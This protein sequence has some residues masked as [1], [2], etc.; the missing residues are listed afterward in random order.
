MPHFKL[1]LIG[2]GNVAKSFV[3]LLERKRSVLESQHG[4]TFSFVGV[5][6]GQH[7][8]AVDM[9][10]LDPFLMR[11]SCCL[12]HPESSH[13]VIRMCKGQADVMFETSP[14]NNVTGQPAIEHVALA[15][16]SGM[17]VITANK[18]TVVHGYNPLMQTAAEKE[19]MFLHEATVMGGTPVFSVFRECM[20]AAELVS[21]EGIINSTTNVILTRMETGE[22]FDDAVSFCQ[23]IG[24]AESDP[25]N[26][27]DGW[28]AAIKVAALVTVLMGIPTTPQQVDRK[29]IRGVTPQDIADATKDGK[30]WKLVA[31][32]DKS[33]KKF[34]VAPQLVGPSSPLY[35]MS[36]ATAGLNF[37]T[38]VIGDL[39]IVDTEREGMTPGPDP[40]AYGLLADFIS[41]ARKTK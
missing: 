19:K 10:G 35:G 37:R 20:P 27:V 39:A 3:R 18:G 5:A 23:G 2:F 1:V 25:S 15:L 11:S 7:G 28:D 12:R 31:S 17:H 40:T 24:L 13:D 9:D 4:I 36:G 21:F 26:D 6:T 38:D 30:R 32:A 34:V 41:I 16:A 8:F 33:T 29:G 14:V 22:S